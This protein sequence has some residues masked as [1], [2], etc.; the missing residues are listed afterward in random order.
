MANVND[1]LISHSFGFV[2]QNMFF[3]MR[4]QRKCA[5]FACEQTFKLNV[6]E[7]HIKRKRV[8]AN[9][10]HNLHNVE[11]PVPIV[12]ECKFSFQF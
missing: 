10:N 6:A 3:H 12:N 5:L 9:R 11:C 2:L 1:F 4:I 7:T 8:D